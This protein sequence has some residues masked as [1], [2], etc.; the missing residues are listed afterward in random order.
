MS[1]DAPPSPGRG[2]TVREV[3]R[4]YRVSTDKVRSWIKRGELMAINT[5]TALCG[6][7]RFVVLPHHLAAFEQKRASGP[8]PK[9]PRRG[10]LGTLVDYYPY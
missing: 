5:A 8:E 3:A 1:A 4:R 10:R 2:L 7:R 6:K 9:R